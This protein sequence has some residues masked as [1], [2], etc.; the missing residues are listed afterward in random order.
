MKVMLLSRYA[1]LGASSRVRYLQYLPYLESQRVF[2]E[3]RPLFSNP[4]L[5]ALYSG[6]RARWEV[7]KGYLG[8]VV[9]L[10][11]AGRFDLLII[12]KELFPFLPASAERVLCRLGVPYLV[13]Y[14]DALFHRYDLHES[15]WVRTLLGRKIDKVMQRASLVIAG[16]QYLADRAHAAG[17]RHVEIVPTVVD[18]QRYT[19]GF[20]HGPG[21]PLVVG[22]IGTPKTSRY[23]RPLLPV[24]ERLQ[25]R[26]DVRFV[27]VGANERDFRN[28]PVETQPW[29]EDTEVASIQQFD[30]G[31]MPLQDSPWERGKCGYK[32]I[33]YLAC[34]VP[35]VASPVGVNTDIVKPEENGLLADTLEEWEHSL[36]RLIT[37]SPQGRAALGA[38]GRRRVVA[39]YSLEA[40]APRLLAL[41]RKAANPAV[42]DA[43]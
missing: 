33:Q 43:V 35:V 15:R 8:R 22:W 18:S 16:N 37:M 40:Q 10:M 30:I 2:L 14:D 9:A 34:G 1:N 20:Q 11:R 17:A 32:L 26:Y 5:E 24:F 31:I 12:E 3:V 7:I 13:D 41:I 23:L 42:R 25:G 39:R 27:A 19:P 38:S 29:S 36:K 28:S 6:R 21:G 4:Y